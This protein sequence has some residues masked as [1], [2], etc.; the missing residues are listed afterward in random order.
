VPGSAGNIKAMIIS[1]P[2]SEFVETPL[3]SV[4][5]IGF[6]VITVTAVATLAAQR[7]RI[8]A[9][10]VLVFVGAVLAFVPGVPKITLD[11]E[12]VLLIL[13]PPLLY[14][15]GVG[16]S[17]RGFRKYLQPIMMLAIGCVIFTAALVAAA[18]HWLLGLSWPV[19]FVLG[20]IVS[21]PDAVAPMAIARRLAI[22]KALLVILE[23]EGL[24]N[25]ATALILFSFSLAA[26]AEVR[27]SIVAALGTFVAIVAGELAWGVA[28]GWASL[29]LRRYAKNP[30]VEMVFALL[31]PYAAFWVP[32]ALGGSGV[33]ATVAAG[34]Y[35]SW[36]GP[37][38]IAPATRLQGFFVWGLVTHIVEGVVFAL[39]GLQAHIIAAGLDDEGWRRLVYASVLTT[40]VV[41]IVRFVWVFPATY[42]PRLLL[43][44]APQRSPAPPWQ[45]PFLIG[46][47][48]VRGVVSLVAALSIP[49]FIDELPFP[50]RSLV[51]CVT[52]FVI[53]VSL[54]GQGT[55]LPSLIGWL[56]LAQIGAA[57]NADAKHTELA[58]RI[59]GI[60]SVLARLEQ[61]PAGHASA[62]IIAE[63]R[64]RHENRRRRYVA[65]FEGAL[66]GEEI[67][68]EAALEL[69]LV[70]TERSNLAALYA[71]AAISDEARRRI[72]RELDLE[73]AL[74]RHAAQS[75]AS[76]MPDAL[77]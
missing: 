43:S 14:T 18:G 50:D 61:E 66:T 72:E 1:A 31:T 44:R 28:L 38:Y 47:T 33:L 3:L 41:T 6:G 77:G 24:V 9:S 75:A 13:L 25:D 19:G 23:G 11:P 30:E 52:F 49:V 48:G 53:I 22:P 76:G 60:D 7:L 16:M 55:L 74:V 35:V 15:S 32:H 73:D 8:A 68:A 40:A 5:S 71:N 36:N 26:V 45:Y 56:G 27:F 20:A 59:S 10:L 62:L 29:V 17:W 54:F 57:E 34:L 37:R 67:A 70:N 42:L 39:T 12:I 4:L 64:V 46:F 65:A 21:P 2:I 51:L 69:E 58:A 63:L